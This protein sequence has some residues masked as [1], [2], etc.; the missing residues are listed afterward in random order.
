M[1]IYT[2]IIENTSRGYVN[3]SYPGVGQSWLS[4]IGFNPL[5]IHLNR[6]SPP[7]KHRERL[8]KMLKNSILMTVPLYSFS[9]VKEA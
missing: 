9:E 3:T 6:L 5:D 1:R 8:N 7:W 2:D 4:F